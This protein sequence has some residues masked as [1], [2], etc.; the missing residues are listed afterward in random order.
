MTLKQ[1]P[2]LKGNEDFLDSEIR[3][4][5]GSWMC[6]NPNTVI[7]EANHFVTKI[8]ER[9]RYPS[10]PRL[11]F[12]M[13]TSSVTLG[14]DVREFVPHLAGAMVDA[15]PRKSVMRGTYW[16][17]SAIHFPA[18]GQHVVRL[19]GDLEQHEAWLNQNLQGDWLCFDKQG[20]TNCHF[21]HE[22]DAILVRL[23]LT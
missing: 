8:T 4:R 12:E 23:S 16:S 22:E 9:M 5:I 21:V 1:I 13:S 2:A 14:F 19:T 20:A 6:V 7:Q 10:A 17:V 15:S 11:G 3:F 18:L